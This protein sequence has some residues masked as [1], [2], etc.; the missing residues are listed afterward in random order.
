MQQPHELGWLPKSKW[1]VFQRKNNE[2]W[3]DDQKLVLYRLKQGTRPWLDAREKFHARGSDVANYMG[4]GFDKFFTFATRTLKVYDPQFKTAWY[5]KLLEE[6]RRD[7]NT[8]PGKLSENVNRWILTRRIQ[9]PIDESGITVNN[10]VDPNVGVSL[11]GTVYNP[12]PESPLPDI[13]VGNYM[14]DKEF[15]YDHSSPEAVAEFKFRVHTE[16]YNVIPKYYMAQIQMQMLIANVRKC[17]FACMRVIPG[18]KKVEQR[19]WI[20]ERSDAY[21]NNYML[22]LMEL[23]IQALERQD[24]D[25]IHPKI[26]EPFVRILSDETLIFSEEVVQAAI[27]LTNSSS[28]WLSL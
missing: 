16:I 24:V 1:Q 22:P 27:R 15:L 17:Y 26:E 9:K 11:D 18:T 21:I 14:L 19:L 5:D 13:Y 23:G 25:F 7:I 2:R 6:Q 3:D 28:A 10:D 12:F 20:V 4:I 8:T